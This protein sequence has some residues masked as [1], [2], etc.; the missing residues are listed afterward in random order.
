MDPKRISIYE[1]FCLEQDLTKS[2][3]PQF[4]A[5]K[6]PWMSYAQ[7]LEEYLPSFF[8]ADKE[9]DGQRLASFTNKLSGHILKIRRMS[10]SR[11]NQ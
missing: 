6:K 8:H 7:D 5:Y 1:G 10:K 9:E 11:R 3:D 2:K 4:F